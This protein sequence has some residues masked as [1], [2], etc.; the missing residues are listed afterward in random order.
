MMAD[1]QMPIL[2]ADFLRHNRFLVDLATGQMSA[3][4]TME[5]FGLAA[6]ATLLANIQAMLPQFAVFSRCGYTWGE[7][8]KRS[9]DNRK[10]IYK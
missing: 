5:R 9:A 10:P 7:H 8:S 2:N 4:T 6:L 3:T 1:V